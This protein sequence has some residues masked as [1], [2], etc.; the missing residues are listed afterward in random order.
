MIISKTPFRVSLFGGGTDYSEFYSR[1]G[2]ELVGFCLK[3]YNYISFRR[4]P[5]I[6]PYKTRVSYSKTEVVDNNKHIQ[7]NGVRGVLE[8]FDI[9]FGVDINNMSELPAQNWN[10]IIFVF[11]SGSPQRY[12]R[13]KRQ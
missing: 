12:T 4:T 6:I 1:F 11:Y 9:K 10:R 5:S 7:H 13:F 8:Y 2:S 3:K